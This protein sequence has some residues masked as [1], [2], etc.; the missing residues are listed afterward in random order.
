MNFLL[1]NISTLSR[2][3]VENVVN[4]PKI[5]IMKKYLISS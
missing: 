4:E 2:E 3:N 5:P 1:I